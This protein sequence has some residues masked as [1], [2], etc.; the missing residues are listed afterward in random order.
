MSSCEFIFLITS[1]ACS[2]SKG[3]SQEEIELLAA[4]FS[5]LGDTLSTIS[6]VQNNCED[7]KQ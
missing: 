2:I 4:A 5:Q 3:K 7:Q 1:L 6:A